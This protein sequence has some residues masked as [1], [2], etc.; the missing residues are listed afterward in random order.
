MTIS[1]PTAAAALHPAG[2]ADVA[3]GRKVDPE[4]FDWDSFRSRIE[5]LVT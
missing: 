2:H 5:A 4:N 1:D 3:P